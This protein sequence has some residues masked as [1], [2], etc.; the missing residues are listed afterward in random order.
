MD[1]LTNLYRNRAI[2]LQNKV[3]LLEQKLQEAVDTK[4][5]PFFSLSDLGKEF[6]TFP[7]SKAVA[8]VAA[9]VAKK[10]AHPIQTTKA[11]ASATGEAIAKAV[12]QPGSA[13]KAAVTSGPAKFVGTGLAVGLPAYYAGHYAGKLADP[14]LQNIP[15]SDSKITKPWSQEGVKSGIEFGAME[16]T[17]TPMVNLFTKTPWYS[18]LGTNTAVGVV[19]GLLAPTV[20]DAGM[21]AGKALGNYIFWGDPVADLTKLGT[22]KAVQVEQPSAEKLEL[23][24]TQ[25]QETEK[26][27]S[28]P[29]Y[30]SMSDED[31]RKQIESMTGTPQ[32]K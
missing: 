25:P 19:G 7:A 3:K 26:T 6:T 30:E 13:L 24:N 18:R 12:Q 2:Q 5:R 28:E 22:P 21:E 31:L 32:T 20:W 9:D 17:A 1:Q 10:A 27:E 29:D 11:A 14:L 15:P 4:T 23:L 8:G 16:A